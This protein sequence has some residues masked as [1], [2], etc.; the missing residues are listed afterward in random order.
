MHSDFQGFPPIVGIDG[1]GLLLNKKPSVI[2]IDRSRRPHTL[3]PAC[4]PPDTQKPLW[5]VSDVILWLRQY[6]EHE[7][8]VVKLGAPTKSEQI[9]KRNAKKSLL[10]NA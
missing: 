3:P 9:A 2:T 10:N 1:L 5:V 4:T 6:V 7:K 8:T